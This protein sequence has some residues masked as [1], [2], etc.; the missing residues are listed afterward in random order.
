MD[1]IKKI[2]KE[3]TDVII[4]TTLNQAVNYLPLAGLFDQRS[5]E[6][7]PDLYAIGEFTS[8][9][10]EMKDL[11]KNSMDQRFSHDLWH[12]NLCKTPF[13]VNGDKVF[14]YNNIKK[15][16]LRD[17]PDTFVSRIKTALKIT[18]GNENSGSLSQMKNGKRVFL[19]NLTG[20]QRF[21]AF[22]IIE[23]VRQDCKNTHYIMYLEGNSGKITLGEKNEQN[24]I[25]Y[26][27]IGG[28]EREDLKLEQIFGLAGF[29]FDS[30][31]TINLLEKQYFN[32]DEE[33]ALGKILE[34]FLSDTG[35]SEVMVESNR[36]KGKNGKIDYKE[37]YRLL[38]QGL[39]EK[40]DVKID[41]FKDKLKGRS[42]PAGY[43]LEYLALFSIAELIKNSYN[44]KFSGLYHNIRNYQSESDIGSKAQ[45]CEFDIV[46][47]TKKGQLVIFECKSGGMSGETGKARQYSTYA[48]GGV[49]GM[50]ILITPLLEGQINEISGKTFKEGEPY[51][52]VQGAMNSAKRNHMKIWCLDNIEDKLK[53]FLSELN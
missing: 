16:L 47:M 42:F 14:L 10:S 5:K 7:F 26:H 18:I 8:E 22:R 29:K 20:G 53:K 28:Y 17:E 13:Y 31:N 49:Y 48:V 3:C 19:W 21:L 25:I 45:F 11:K 12:D 15:I 40:I 38:Q 52:Y 44:G 46:L 6:D 9:S 23:L 50:P 43:L 37:C 41:V 34:E 35:V 4:C 24:E 2:Y 51:Y 27:E 32:K 33:Q 1:D 39:E 36:G 30:K